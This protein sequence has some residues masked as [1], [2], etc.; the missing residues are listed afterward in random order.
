M[1]AADTAS[2]L[3]AKHGEPVTLKTVA[4]ASFDPVTGAPIGGGGVTTSY[5]GNGYPSKYIST[6][7]DGT[8]I[9]QGDIR[10]IMELITVRPQRGWTATVDNVTYQIMD[11]QAIRQSGID[12]LYILQLRAS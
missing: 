10:L 2:K 5:T 12:Q 11:V 9:K 4:T 6:D 8:N 7:V 1:S 3:L